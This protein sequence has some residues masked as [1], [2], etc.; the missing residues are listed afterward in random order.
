[1]TSLLDADVYP[2]EQFAEAQQVNHI[3]PH[4]PIRV[5]KDG[6]IGATTLP[7]TVP[8]WDVHEGARANS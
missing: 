4:T 6:T 5:S 8:G 2:A 7:M 1:M 3:A